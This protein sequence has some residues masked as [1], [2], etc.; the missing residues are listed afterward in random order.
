MSD[1]PKKQSTT[2]SRFNKPSHL[3]LETYLLGMQR[4]SISSNNHY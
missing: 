2:V 4:R 3:L 1:D